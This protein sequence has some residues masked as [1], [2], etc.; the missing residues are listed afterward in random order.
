[1]PDPFAAAILLGTLA[2]LLSR[3]VG[4]LKLMLAG[5]ALG[6]L[7]SRLSTLPV[8]GVSV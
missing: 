5:G 1:M 4:P 2:A 8:A 6:A 7:R 3:R